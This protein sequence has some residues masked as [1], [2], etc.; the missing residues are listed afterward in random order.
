[1]YFQNSN[2]I[3]LS[4]DTEIISK[5]VEAADDIN[6]ELRIKFDLAEIILELQENHYNFTVLDCCNKNFE[7]IN[8]VKVIKKIKS[9]MPVIIITNDTEK[10]IGAK[11]YEQNIFYLYISQESKELLIEIFTAAI[12][13]ANIN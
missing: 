10:N 4:S 12:E 2:G 6:C 3:L 8:W 11:L 13:H 7:C 9:N 1:M 5:C